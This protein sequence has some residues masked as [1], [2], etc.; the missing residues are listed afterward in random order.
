MRV[1]RPLIL[2]CSSLFVLPSVATAQNTASGTATAS[3]QAATILRSALTA[4][5]GNTVVADVTLTGTVH[6]VAGSTDET[7]TAVL[8]A[9]STGEASLAL[10]LPSGSITEVRSSIANGPA[11]SWTDADGVTHEMS[12]HNCWTDAGWFFP[13]FGS[14]FVSNQSL[15]ITYV[16]QETLDGISVQHIQVNRIVPGDANGTPSS[17]VSHLSQ[18]DL[19]FDAQSYLPVQSEFNIHPDNDA[20][21]DIPVVV[22][23]SDYRSV[24]GTQMPFHIQKYIQNGL[25]LD[26]QL[27]SAT[28]NSGLTSSQFQVQ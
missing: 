7:G 8:K 27:S 18:V 12:M 21:I 15:Q 10:N 5:V 20:G 24:S 6:R 11:G 26:V 23:Y 17:L 14:A 25:Q 13:T 4:L 22:K 9:L 16:G 19:Y 28:V 3:P 2:F 1:P